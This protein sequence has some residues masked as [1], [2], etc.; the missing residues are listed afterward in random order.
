MV[1]TICKSCTAGVVWAVTKSGRRMP[2]NV[3]PDP[4]GNV[5]LKTGGEVPVAVV[6]VQP[7]AE[8]EVRYTSHL[9]T[10][11]NAA[12]HRTREDR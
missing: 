7:P 9:A 5:I 4:H 1:T 11:P 2:I 12:Q 6:T 10:C 3:T 8:G